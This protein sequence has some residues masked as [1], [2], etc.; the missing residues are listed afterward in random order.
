[1]SNK[2]GTLLVKAIHIGS[3]EMSKKVY[4][5]SWKLPL[6][7]WLQLVVWGQLDPGWPVRKQCAH[8]QHNRWTFHTTALLFPLSRWS[9]I[10]PPSP[11]P[12]TSSRSC[13]RARTP[14]SRHGS[15]NHDNSTIALIYLSRWIRPAFQASMRSTGNRSLR[16][17]DENALDWFYE[18]M[19][20]N[21][22]LVIFFTK[23][24]K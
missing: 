9:S 11:A 24:F 1:M 20:T 4:K 17:V 21:L 14:A 2:Y 6:P 16:I 7:S 12:D 5:L 3:D 19:P 15:C 22:I 13:G 23:G 10:R 18:N 8:S